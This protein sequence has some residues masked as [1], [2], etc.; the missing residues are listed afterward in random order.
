[1]IGMKHL[2]EEAVHGRVLE[3]NDTLLAEAI[4]MVKINAQ[5]ELSSQEKMPQ[6]PVLSYFLVLQKYAA[7]IPTTRSTMLAAQ[8]FV[9]ALLYATA[10]DFDLV[11]NSIAIYAAKTLVTLIGKNE[12]GLTLNR[13]AV[14]GLLDVFRYF[15]DFTS[16]H[17]K[18]KRASKK[19]ASEMVRML[20]R[21]L[22]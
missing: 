19:K 21:E 2:H 22:F 15:W 1:M 12:G 11:G 3:A 13:A 18:I 6:Y 7:G 10:N 5:G 9:K 17:W 4:H 14:E 8:G 16:S 20:N